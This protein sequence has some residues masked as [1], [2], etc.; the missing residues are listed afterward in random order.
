MCLL[1]GRVPLSP[2]PLRSNRSTRK[3][4]PAQ[5]SGQ[6]DPD[7]GLADVVGVALVDQDD[8]GGLSAFRAL[9]DDAEEAERSKLDRGLDDRLACSW[10][11]SQRRFHR[12]GVKVTGSPV[13]ASASQS[14]TR[15]IVSQRGD[16]EL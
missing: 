1:P 6:V 2:L 11:A 5:L 3:P 4:G 15:S 16:L 14:A 13:T 7:T 10:S 8:G 9:G 12:R